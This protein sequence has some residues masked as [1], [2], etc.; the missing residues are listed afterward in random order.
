M[1]RAMLIGIACA[2]VATAT[3]GCGD[4]ATE[5]E[6]PT[7]FPLDEGTIW[8]YGSFE[9]SVIA[10]EKFGGIHYAKH[11][12]ISL[13]GPRP[14]FARMSSGGQFLVFDGEKEKVLFDFAAPVGTTWIWTGSIDYQITVKNRDLPNVVVPAG[15]FD[16]CYLF[17][18]VTILPSFDSSW[19]FI[20]S[21]G[22]GVLVKSGG[23]GFF[24]VLEGF[25]SA[26]N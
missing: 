16:G 19:E 12:G 13:L 3:I 25:V 26:E 2:A 1:T 14:L 5:P 6:N 4:D 9:D 22:T 8:N 7:I 18:A 17:T 21:P 10:V 11:T 20:V 15:S 23:L 24:F